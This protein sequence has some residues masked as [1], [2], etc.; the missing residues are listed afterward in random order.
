MIRKLMTWLG[1]TQTPQEARRT[2]LLAALVVYAVVVTV[3][4]LR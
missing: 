4:L 2:V 3:Y 1:K